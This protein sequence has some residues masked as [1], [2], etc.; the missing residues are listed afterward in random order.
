MSYV[1]MTSFSERASSRI[2]TFDET[3]ALSLK[4]KQQQ[5]NR[6]ILTNTTIMMMVVDTCGPLG[7]KNIGNYIAFGWF[8][9]LKNHPRRG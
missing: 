8:T 1:S 3:A 6:N 7:A 2:P 4:K 5:I 9:G